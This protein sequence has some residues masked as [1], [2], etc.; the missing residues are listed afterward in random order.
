MHA[1]Q[2]WAQDDE[3]SDGDSRSCIASWLVNFIARTI[4]SLVNKKALKLDGHVPSDFDYSGKSP[5][6]DE[7]ALQVPS[8]ILTAELLDQPVSCWIQYE[9]ELRTHGLSI[10]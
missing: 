1:V 3:A 10:L 2:V 4:G 6:Y 8:C 7:V 9:Y 5:Q